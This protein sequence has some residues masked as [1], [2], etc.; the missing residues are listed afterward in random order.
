MV[1]EN[2]FLLA[3][4]VSFLGTWSPRVDG[5]EDEEGFDDLDNESDLANY[6]RRDHHGGSD[7]GLIIGRG[8]SNAYAYSEVD[9]APLNPNIH[10]LTYGQEVLIQSHCI[11]AF[12]HL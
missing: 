2:E 5:D 6:P 7:G 8:T 12:V 11:Y 1:L 10:L 3:E 4:S 9:G